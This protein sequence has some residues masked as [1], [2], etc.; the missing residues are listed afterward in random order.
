MRFGRAA[1]TAASES[2]PTE[3]FAGASFP[4]ASFRRD[5]RAEAVKLLLKY[6]ART[7]LNESSDE[8]RRLF[9][10]QNSPKP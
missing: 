2:V 8:I 6:G 3:P 9:K 1:A 4:V 10:N 7:D 5:R